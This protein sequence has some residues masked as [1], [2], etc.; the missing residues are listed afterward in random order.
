MFKT[1]LTEVVNRDM[2]RVK[3][4]LVEINKENIYKNLYVFR[5]GDKSG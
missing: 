1:D 3:E 2:E 5:K 4:D